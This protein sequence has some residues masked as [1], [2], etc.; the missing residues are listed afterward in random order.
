MKE[1][2]GRD[3]GGRNASAGVTSSTISLILAL[4]QDGLKIEEIN[5]LVNDSTLTEKISRVYTEGRSIYLFDNIAALGKD[6]V[7]NDG[8]RK[9]EMSDEEYGKYLMEKD[10]FGSDTLCL[11]IKCTGRVIINV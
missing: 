11:K 8:T 9:P 10:C 5:E 7:C 1:K 3:P 4:A 2:S 6:P